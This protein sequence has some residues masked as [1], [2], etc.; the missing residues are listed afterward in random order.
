MGQTENFLRTFENFLERRLKRFV[1]TRPEAI[2][3]DQP[4]NKIKLVE[5][6]TRVAA[7]TGMQARAFMQ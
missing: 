4:A 1:I 6:K 2:C 5:C 3:F 7:S